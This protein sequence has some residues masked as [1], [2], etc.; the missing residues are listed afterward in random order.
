MARDTSDSSRADRIHR[1]HKE[2][3]DPFE[4]DTLDREYTATAGVSG[5]MLPGEQHI[6][7]DVF[8][9]AVESYD[10]RVFN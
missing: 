8:R 4:I 6:D 1:T 3:V 5:F 7:P 2:Y 9:V 10:K